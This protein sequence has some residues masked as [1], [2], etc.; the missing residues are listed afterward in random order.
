MKKYFV[1]DIK[2]GSDLQNEIFAVKKSK[3]S[4][5]K[6][7]KPYIDLEL[8]DKTGIIKAK[9]WSDSIEVCDEV[10]AGSVVRI[11]GKVSNFNDKP[12]IS[13]SALNETTE[14]E[15]S[16][17]LP[18]SSH[19]LTEM[20]SDFSKIL[21]SINDSNI[22]QLLDN[23]LDTD[24]F[25]RF[26]TAPAAYTVHHAYMGGL[27][28]HTLDLLELA[29]VAV[30]RYPKINRDLL[31]AG[32]ILHDIGKLQEYSMDTTIQMTKQGKLL[33]HIYLGAELV[34]L[35]APKE[36]P[37]DMIEEIIHMILS[38]QGS[39][40]FGSPILPKTPEA[41]ALSTLDDASFKINTVYNT[42]DK[43]EGDEEFTDYQRHLGTDLYRSP[44]HGNLE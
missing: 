42:I 13:I 15:A 24:T 37:E 35:K 14:Y 29:A 3:K 20:K 9:V 6:D 21:E 8:S 27:L 1:K 10:Q 19:D 40:E 30:K 4:L 32:C 17:L 26:C 2:A 36:M 11:F 34:R 22:K 7:G 18:T 23:I 41:I 31:F 12:Q 43:F 39:L 33:G 5:T 25:D 16:D 44:Y 38:H 28:E